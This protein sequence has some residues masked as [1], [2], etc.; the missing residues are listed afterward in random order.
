MAWLD[1]V[2]IVCRRMVLGILTVRRARETTDGQIDSW[3]T[4]LALVIAV[5]N[6]VLDRIVRTRVFQNVRDRPVNFR[7]AAPDTK[8]RF[9]ELNLLA[10]GGSTA[11][12]RKLIQED[13][14]RWGTVIKRAGI[15]LD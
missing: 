15:S 8:K 6:E 3:R 7:I 1:K 5:R 13:T 4:V 14:E 2:E 9:E 11:D 10:A 12:M